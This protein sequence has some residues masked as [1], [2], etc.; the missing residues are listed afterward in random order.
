[1]LRV[2]VLKVGEGDHVL[3]YVMHHIVSDEWSTGILIKELRALYQAYLEG[4]ESPLPELEIQY[5]DFAVW[6]RAYLAGEV[7]EREVGYWRE[8]LKG[9]AAL[10][11]PADRPRP[12]EP[13]YR[14]GLERVCLSQSVSEGLRRLSRREGVT[15]FMILM[16]TF[17]A[18]LMRYSGQE[19]ISVGTP[20]ANRT[21]REVEGLIG[22][23]VN[24]LVMR[25]DL[26]GNPSF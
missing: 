15:L 18:L 26:S 2:N 21:R 20:I 14:G 24:T 13:S 4:E 5:A 6:Q 9:A 1:L 17:K 25:T 12:A 22:F 19:D 10:E 3:L 8:Q 7:L 11:L 23:F 16:A